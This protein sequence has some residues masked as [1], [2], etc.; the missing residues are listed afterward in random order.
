MSKE[1]FLKLLDEPEIQ[2]KIFN[3]V[4]SELFELT[5]HAELSK[6]EP[7][8][9]NL[10]EEK[11]SDAQVEEVLENDSEVVAAEKIPEPVEV[12]AE[13]IPEP[14]SEVEEKISAEEQPE[15]SAEEIYFAELDKKVAEEKFESPDAEDYIPLDLIGISEDEEEPAEEIIQPAEPPAPE[16]VQEVQEVQEKKSASE[17][18]EKFTIVIERKCPVCGK[19][20]HIVKAKVRQV[21]DKVD[22]DF[23]TH[24]KNFNPYLYN[25]WACEHCGFAAE[26]TKFSAPMPK[27]TRD[28]IQ[29]FLSNNQLVLPFIRE[30]TVKDALSFYEMAILFLEVFDPSPGRQA[31]L[32]Q[33]MAWIERCEGKIELERE[34]LLKTAELY[35]V[36]LKKERYPIGNV[37]DTAAAFIVGASYFLIGEYDKAETSLSKIMERKGLRSSAPVF[38]DKAREIWQEIRRKK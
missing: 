25:V 24:Y 20:T 19:S 30:R 38:Y 10:V 9:E 8:Q 29:K 31:S 2:R 12:I 1:E 26:E 35:E 18:I 37:T 36:S 32:Y 27:V 11:I 21:V 16:P 34:Y 6:A 4:C 23:C 5:N 28:K 33:K 3:I 15:L 22:I 14:E 7:P 13:K 17:S